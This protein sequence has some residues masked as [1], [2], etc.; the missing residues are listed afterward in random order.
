MAGLTSF[1]NKMNELPADQLMAHSL[2]LC[3]VVIHGFHSLHMINAELKVDFITDVMPFHMSAR[4][5]DLQQ[6]CSGKATHSTDYY[7]FL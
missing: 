7:L 2:V 6:K 3:S 4:V 5:E 1:A